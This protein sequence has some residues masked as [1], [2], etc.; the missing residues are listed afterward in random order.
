MLFSKVFTIVAVAAGAAMA[1]DHEDDDYTTLTSTTTRTMT[2]TACNPTKT[3]CPYTKYYPLGN[4]TSTYY[5]TASGHSSPS[6]DIVTVK[7]TTSTDVVVAA[8]TPAATT[9][10]SVT[11]GSGN[12]MVQSGLLVGAIAVGVAALF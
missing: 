2:V 8:P 3:D 6:A 12:L 11:A 7:P 9:S 1:H 10:R 4:T 5:P